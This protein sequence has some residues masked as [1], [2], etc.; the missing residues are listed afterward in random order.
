M[1]KLTFI[2]TTSLASVS[3]AQESYNSKEYYTWDDDADAQ[4]L[5]ILIDTS[6]EDAT[7]DYFIREGVHY[8]S[9]NYDEL[10]TAVYDWLETPY[11]YAGKGEKGI[12]CSGLV[13]AVYKDAYNLVLSGSSRDLYAQCDPI[14]KDELQEGDL[15]FFKINRSV[16]SHVG[17]YLG[18]NIFVHASSVRGVTLSDLTDDYY[19][20][21]FYSAGRIRPINDTADA[22]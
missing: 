9:C 16:I 22:E 1:K 4:M 3:I 13:K 8:D 11:K 14:D 20:R 15:V 10:Y 2:I 17:L 12:D 7:I 19:V 21:Y 18:D 5:A 6:W